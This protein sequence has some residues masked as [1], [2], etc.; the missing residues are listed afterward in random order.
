MRTAVIVAL[1]MAFVVPADAG[2]KAGVTMP[3]TLEVSGK[4]LTLNGMG[5]REATWL[6]IDVYVAG[7][8]LENVSSNADAIVTSKQAKVLM[9]KFV[10]D[11]GRKDIVKAWTEG[12][13]NNAT[14]KIAK[15][16]PL[17]DQ[18]NGWM[19]GFDDG[20]LLTFSYVPGTGVAVDINGKR[21]GLIN[22]DDFAHSLFAIW[23]GPKPPTGALKTGLLGKHP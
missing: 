19:V 3:D 23:L 12:F 22:D 8:Y 1:L 5:L 21:K 2:K 14:V 18:L 7:L 17:I 9:L 15:I 20:D 11:V 16:Q 4:Q 10:R 13:Q 6:K